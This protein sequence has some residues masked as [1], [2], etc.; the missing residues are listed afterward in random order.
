MN[1]GMLR[2]VSISR[3]VKGYTKIL[4]EAF[5]VQYPEYGLTENTIDTIVAA[6]ALHD[7]GKIAIPDRILLK[8]GRL[9]KDE[10]EYMKSHTIRGCEILESMKVEWNPAMKKI[11]L[12]IIR[13]HHERYDGKGYPDGLKG[14]EIPISAQLVSVAD[15][16]DALI[17]ELLLQGAS[18]K[19]EAFHMIMNGE[20]GAFYRNCLK[21][22]GV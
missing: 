1:T 20:C 5:R 10:F 22:S 2:V 12:E 6:S 9:D 11:S 18:S 3:R 16:Y 7:L 19:E 17:N 13:H 21:L 14:D 15:V 8:P 4:A